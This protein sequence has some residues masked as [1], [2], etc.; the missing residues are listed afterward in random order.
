[1]VVVVGRLLPPP[2]PSRVA[3]GSWM[4]RGPVGSGTQAAPR[5]F[6][7]AAARRGVAPF[8]IDCSR[9]AGRLFMLRAVRLRVLGL[10]LLCAACLPCLALPAC[11][12]P[13]AGRA[14]ASR[15]LPT[16]CPPSFVKSQA[17]LP[18]L[19]PQPQRRARA[20]CNLC[21]A[22]RAP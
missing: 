4:A 16:A 12:G 10:L 17:R 7:A 21:S 9:S 20:C 14:E 5:L 22:V 1:M 11:F 13:T 19:K 3:D 8:S 2:F 15:T 6:P 18:L